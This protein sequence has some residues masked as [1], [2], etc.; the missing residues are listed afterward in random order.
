MFQILI[1]IGKGANEFEKK[2]S[3]KTAYVSF[4]NIKTHTVYLVKIYAICSYSMGCICT[5]DNKTN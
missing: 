4:I 3:Y 2:E 1:W 5:G